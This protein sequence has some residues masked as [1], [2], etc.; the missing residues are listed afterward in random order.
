[1]TDDEVG[2]F[3]SQKTFWDV[4]DDLF[5]LAVDPAMVSLFMGCSMEY[6]VRLLRSL[7]FVFVVVFVPT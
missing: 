4:A 1:M 5:H 3:L 7:R 2:V 6:G